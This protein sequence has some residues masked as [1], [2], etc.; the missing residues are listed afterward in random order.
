MAKAIKYRYTPGEIY[1]IPPKD[2]QHSGE[3]VHDP[4]YDSRGTDKEDPFIAALAGKM[5]KRG[6]LSVVVAVEREDIGK[7]ETYVQVVGGRNRLEAAKQARIKEIPVVFL[8]PTLPESEQISEMLAENTL[9]K[10]ENPVGLAKKVA[11]AIRAYCNEKF[12]PPEPETTGD[13]AKDAAA[14]E[15]WNLWEPNGTQLKEARLVVATN[16]GYDERHLRNILALLDMSPKVVAAVERGR[17]GEH[18]TRAWRDLE[19]PDQDAAL[20]EFLAANPEKGAGGEAG[21]AGPKKGKGKG[22]LTSARE[23]RDAT[24][25]KAA[26]AARAAGAETETSTTTGKSRKKATGVW[27][28]RD[29]AIRILSQSSVPGAVRNLGM[30]LAGE[31]SEDEACGKLGWLSE[32][33]EAIDKEDE[34]EWSE[35]KD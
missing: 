21:A 16:M 30:F 10:A 35:A 13:E 19:H 6:F 11:R 26:K 9:R 18:A 5:K 2:V 28:D 22:G 20:A 32:A 12:C 7:G 33:L 25:K 8:D 29:L 23:A 3:G 34:G 31:V 1:L 4:L 17:L 15:K 24:S 14:H 27:I